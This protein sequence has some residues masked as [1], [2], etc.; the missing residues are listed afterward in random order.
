LEPEVRN[1]V[2]HKGFEVRTEVYHLDEEEMV[3]ES[4]Y[5]P[6]GDY[7]GNPTLADYLVTRKGIV[8]ETENSGRHI[9]TIG[10]CEIEQ[11]WYGWSHLAM[12]GFGVG[13]IVDEGSILANIGLEVGMEAKTLDDA[14]R[15]AIIFASLA[16]SVPDSDK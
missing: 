4:A 12:H 6:S 14:R 5:T 11:K 3:I 1:V 9:C 13:A 16:A 15:M 10:W 2:Q 7:I 8:P